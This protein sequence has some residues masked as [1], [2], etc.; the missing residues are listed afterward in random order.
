MMLN[1]LDSHD[2]HR[3]FTEVGKDKEKLLAALALEMIL[4]GA[5][6]MYYGT[7]VCLEGGYDP[8]SR[9]CFPWDSKQWDMDFLEKVKALLSLRREPLI[10]DGAV[11]ITAECELLCVKR[12]DDSGNVLGLWINMTDQDRMLLECDKRTILFGNRFDGTRIEQKGFVITRE[13]E[14]CDTDRRL[15]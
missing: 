12:M 8:D 3:F 11:R 2:T 14:S 1:L 7:E 10:A 6:C 13:Q 4:P 9:R 5:P 15:G